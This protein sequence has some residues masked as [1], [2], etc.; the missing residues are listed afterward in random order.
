MRVMAEDN[1]R[2]VL[3]E[4]L[5]SCPPLSER[6]YSDL[7]SGL[8]VDGR[9]FLH[10]VPLSHFVGPIRDWMTTV[11]DWSQM[12]L[13]RPGLWTSSTYGVTARWDQTQWN[14]Q[15]FSVRSI[16]LANEQNGLETLRLQ[17]ISQHAHFECTVVSSDRT[18][19]QR[20]SAEAEDGPFLSGK[21][22]DVRRIERLLSGD[23]A[24]EVIVHTGTKPNSVSILEARQ[25][26]EAVTV[27]ARITC[28]ADTLPDTYQSASSAIVVDDLPS[29]AAVTMDRIRQLQVEAAGRR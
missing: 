1:N 24:C 12:G 19:L 11:R 6:D 26:S 3:A 14:F 25:P 10:D 5:E 27:L 15:P 8:E 22:S 16:M 29:F 20:L 2:H 18:N 21:P 4:C 17:R 28:P 23:R 9:R 13:T 7:T